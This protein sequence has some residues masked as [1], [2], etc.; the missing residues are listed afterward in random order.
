MQQQ[1][2]ASSNKQFLCIEISNTLQ[3][4]LPTQQLSEIITL[5]PR[6]ILQI[7]EMPPA[8]AG[9]F[10]WH[11]EI[12]WLIDISYL[13]GF[14]PILS[15]R[16]YAQ[17]K[18]RVLKVKNQGSYVG[19]LVH[20]IGNLTSCEATDIN[21][22]VPQNLPLIIEKCTQGSCKNQTG[23]TLMIL[24]VEAIIQNIEPGLS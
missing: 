17:H 13:M 2:T 20:K 14:D 4:M 10:N 8:V 23:E 21:F 24:D 12:L 9:I 11:G 7:P 5:E 6:K 22:L 3:V 15:L 18:C 16:F 1:T 19:F